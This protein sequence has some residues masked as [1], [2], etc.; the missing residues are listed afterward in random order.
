[1]SDGWDTGEIALLE[2]EMA[3]LQRRA[4]AVI[5]I[6]PLKGDAEYEPLAAGMAAAR[7]YCDHF[8]PGHNIESFVEFVRL[9][10]A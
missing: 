7:P 1:M 5:W 2:R 6:N 9:V 4:R 10:R 3:R 8:I